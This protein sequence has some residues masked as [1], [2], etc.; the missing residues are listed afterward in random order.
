ME[1]NKYLRY[2]VLAGTFLIPFVPLIISGNLFFPFITGKAFV[3][4]IITEII[5]T[6]WLILALRDR[7][8]MPK[9]SALLASFVVFT[10]VAL[11][12]NLTA[13]NP[14][15]A[16]WSNFE[17]MEG[18][19][20]ILHLFAYFIVAGSILN[21]DWLWKRFW[22]TF[23]GSSLFIG[24]YALIQI[25]G[26]MQM[27]Q[28]A[29]RIDGTFGNSAYMAVFLL[30]LSFVSLFYLAKRGADRLIHLVWAGFV[31][32][33]IFVVYPFYAYFSSYFEALNTYGK[34]PEGYPLKFFFGPTNQWVFGISIVFIAALL[35]VYIAMD[36][37]KEKTRE[38]TADGMY[39]LLFIFQVYLL[40][41]TA[42]RG[43]ILGMI[44]GLLLSALLVAWLERKNLLMR[45][46]AIGIVAGVAV[47]VS[48]FW[49]IRNTDF[50]RSNPIL[51]RFAVISW[52]ENKTQ[53][54]GYVWPMAIQGFKE[55]PLLGW[56]QEGF[57]F[58]FN[59][60]YNPKMWMHEA[61]FDRAHNVL[62]DWLVAG[63]LLGLLGYLSLFV[64][65][66]YYIWKKPEYPLTL[67]GILKE[68][69][70]WL[71]SL[72]TRNEEFLRAGH[73]TVV[74]KS[75]LTGLL[76]AYFFNNLFVFD[77]LGSYLVFISLL[78]YIHAM[79][80]KKIAL[81]SEE[82]L[83]LGKDT[84]NSVIIPALI[85]AAFLA[86]YLL[87]W[88]GYK[89]GTTL[90]EALRPQQGGQAKQ[91]EYFKKAL[92]YN[93][94]GHQEVVEQLVT[95]TIQAIGN[96]ID[97][98]VAQEYLSV[99]KDA[100][101]KEIV[102][103]PKDSRLHLFY[104]SLLNRT[105]DYEGAVKELSAAVD[106]SPKKQGI[107]F[108]LI[109]TYLNIGQ[110]D[111]ALEIAKKTYEYEPGYP[112]A[113]SIYLAVMAYAEKYDD[114]KKV[115]TGFITESAVGG[116]K[117]AVDQRVFNAFFA[118]QKY[119]ELVDLLKYLLQDDVQ[120]INYR[121]ALARTY[122]ASG[123]KTK[124]VTELESIKKDNA[125]DTN[126]VSQIDGFIIEVNKTKAPTGVK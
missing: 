56:G 9:G 16:F 52:S 64:F 117:Y 111:K 104:G 50:V 46:F 71:V 67:K 14:F 62:L 115:I 8:F 53:A 118:K 75:I 123:Y 48:G 58:V 51:A 21:V 24:L 72:F 7:S 121:V 106:A 31:G 6:L 70:Q 15:K 101:Q 19:V 84:V 78:A 126:L 27:S 55:N 3:F 49:F 38:Y 86:M 90:I 65:A 68:L 119:T 124:A 17:R 82:K 108:E 98:T 25:A 93:S 44:G 107:I 63:G 97:P 32:F 110:F 18:M 80:S 125:A 40:Y 13:D 1:T 109:M 47:L 114:L 4:R 122:F 2:A 77:N 42:T 113:Q 37:W 79:N 11:L 112:E 59:E 66:L 57:N 33:G 54:R 100:M 30:F 29:G 69:W 85:V 20:T 83:S 43:A 94:I 81:F 36:K 61:W 87:N 95:A 45:K 91:L 60:Y 73:L 5:F 88:N 96:K 102:R 26:E 22:H 41:H 12:A 28:G 120:N 103:N 35:F 116:Q 34:I 23:L 92:A 76:A 105:Q 10:V 74:E 89:T 39:I 99:A